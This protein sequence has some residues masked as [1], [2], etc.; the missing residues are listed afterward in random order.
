MQPFTKLKL[1]TIHKYFLFP[2]KRQTSKPQ[3]TFTRQVKRYILGSKLCS[4]AFITIEK[5]QQIMQNNVESQNKYMF[6]LYIGSLFN[7]VPSMA[8]FTCIVISQVFMKI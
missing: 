2:Y 4:R 5:Q 3:Y 7:I 1:K 8:L 6:W